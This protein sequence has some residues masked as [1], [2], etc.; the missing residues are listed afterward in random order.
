M[1][2]YSPNVFLK[3]GRQNKPPTPDASSDTLASLY[4]GLSK[5]QEG[6]ALTLRPVLLRDIADIWETIERPRATNLLFR[7]VDPGQPPSAGLSLNAMMQA[8]YVD[9]L[10][11]FSDDLVWLDDDAL[12]VFKYLGLPSDAIMV[13][14]TGPVEVSDA[15]AIRRALSAGRSPLSAE[16]RAVAVL[17]MPAPHSLYLETRSLQ[18]AL[19]MVAESFRHYL[20]AVLR[21]TV[22]SIA[23]PPTWMMQ[24]FLDIEG[25]LCVR[26]RETDRFATFVD[27]G[28]CVQ[29]DEPTRPADCSLIYDVLG[30]SWHDEP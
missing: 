25:G 3:S 29:H 11:T 9:P 30:N 19:A 26:P 5:T 10:E 12:L 8:V 16:L 23:S 6:Y 18:P 1:F 22:V 13:R 24:R 7:C 2:G 14:I 21:R 15:D 17:G 27:I 4:A 20:A 28:V